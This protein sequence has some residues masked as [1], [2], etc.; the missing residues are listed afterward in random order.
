M[1]LANARLRVAAARTKAYPGSAAYRF[2]LRHSGLDPAMVGLALTTVFT[3]MWT[4]FGELLFSVEAQNWLV[5][6]SFAD[7]V[8][9]RVICNS[10]LV[11]SRGQRFESARRLSIFPANTVNR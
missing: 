1:L 7:R 5:Y 2:R 9:Y 8:A 11:M 10:A 4:V 6:A 3:T